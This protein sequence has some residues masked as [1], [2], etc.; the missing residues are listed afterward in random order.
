MQKKIKKLPIS[1]YFV[2]KNEEERLPIALNSVY[3][4]VDEII[5][6]DSGSSDN[7]VKIAES[8]GAKVIFN[9]WKG[10]AKQKAFAE[11]L[12]KNSW[13]FNLDAD[14]E[15]SKELREKISSLFNNGFPDCSAFL[16]R[17]LTLYLNQQ[18][19]AKFSREDYIIRLYNKGKANIL[20]EEFLNDDRPKV[21][22]GEIHKLKEPVYHRSILS[23]SHLEKKYIQYSDEAAK[24]Y[25]DKKKK[26][27]F[28]KFYFSFPVVFIKYFLFRR[29]FLHGWYGFVLSIMGSYRNFMRLAKTK[30]LYLKAYN[31]K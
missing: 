24:N 7:T 4:W 17:W 27:G 18:K 31:K 16:I 3:E 8:F 1:V 10:Y 12:C 14:E 19:P 20:D 22:E 2:T 9:E 29:M 25:V 6:V 23:L 15:V 28:F 21:N 30:E 26:I 13:V 5:V 11:G